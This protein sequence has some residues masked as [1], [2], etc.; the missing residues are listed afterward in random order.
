MKVNLIFFSLFLLVF[1][2]VCNV[3]VFF[4]FGGVSER[5]YKEIEK[6]LVMTI[7]YFIKF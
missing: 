4:I 5:S 3:F 7:I 1:I 6:I 2:M